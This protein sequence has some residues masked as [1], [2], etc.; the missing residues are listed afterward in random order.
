MTQLLF[1]PK[2]AAVIEVRWCCTHLNQNRVC[3]VFLL[4]SLIILCCSHAS[5][6]TIQPPPQL[7]TPGTSANHHYHNLANWAGKLYFRLDVDV[8]VNAAAV[9]ELVTKAAAE[10]R[11]RLDARV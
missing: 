7:F 8:H 10:V 6:F 4:M 11:Q 1:L 2:H 5:L 3:V 9:A